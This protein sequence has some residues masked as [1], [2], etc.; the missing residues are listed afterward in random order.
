MNRRKLLHATALLFGATLLFSA[1]STSAA[2][3]ANP[4]PK[5]RSPGLSALSTSAD[6]GRYAFVFF[7]KENNDATQRMQGVLQSALAKTK[8]RADVV[9]V[10]V[11]DPTEQ[12]TVKAFGVER[13][14]FPLVVA[15]APNG[16]ITKAWPLQLRPEQLSEGFVSQGTAK[17]I[18]GLQD[19]K[20]VLL[21]VQN[22]STG[23]NLTST[24]AA[25][26][27]R[28][29]ARFAAATEV[30]TLDPADPSESIFMRDLA[31]NP[32]T[33]D[34][35]TILLAP[36]GR[37][38]ARFVGAVSTDEIVTKVTAAQSGCCPGGQCGP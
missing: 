17:C 31:V 36:P 15:V 37:P 32:K 8:N 9:T 16:A 38:V 18:K 12:A 13:A 29:D 14:P 10:S 19:R 22:D 2:G 34:A 27:F 25:E 1:G 24:Q 7:W 20:L 6:Q 26:G 23:H 28:T 5:D 33:A 35:V 30:I 3:T 11:V 21:C 4:W